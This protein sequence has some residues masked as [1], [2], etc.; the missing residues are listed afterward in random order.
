VLTD[1]NFRF[2]HSSS[3]DSNFQLALLPFYSSKFKLFHSVMSTPSRTLSLRKLKVFSENQ[4][5]KSNQKSRDMASHEDVFEGIKYLDGSKKELGNEDDLNEK[6]ST[7][8]EKLMRASRS[9]IGEFFG[10]V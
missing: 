1:F 10:A 8:K 5:E 4:E 6:V 3:R 2:F 9:V 7:M